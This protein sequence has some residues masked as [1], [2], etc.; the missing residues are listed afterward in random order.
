M[1]KEATSKLGEVYEGA[2]IV[3]LDWCDVPSRPRARILIPAAIKT[4]E[5]IL[6][7]LQQCNPHLPTNDWK[8]VKVEE[9]EGD[10]NQIYFMGS[11]TLPSACYILSDDSSIPFYSTSNG[12]N[13]ECTF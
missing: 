11:E 5:D 12:Y 13:K 1:Y 8:V 6:F 2:N 3:A 7:T 4:P 10:V 9:H